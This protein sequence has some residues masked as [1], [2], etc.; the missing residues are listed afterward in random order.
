M[1]YTLQ[2]RPE[3]LKLTGKAGDQLFVSVGAG[4]RLNNTLNKLLEQITRIEPKVNTLQQLRASVITHWIKTL[5]LRE[6]QYR[7]GHRYVSSTEAYLIND[8]EG[9]AEDVARFHPIG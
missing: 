3:L 5:N 6:A 7:A 1:E 2:T 4:S 8:L 9:L